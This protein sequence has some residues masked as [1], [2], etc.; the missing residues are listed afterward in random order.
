MQG[1]F[2]LRGEGGG[3]RPC[4][5]FDLLL[6][7]SFFLLKLSVFFMT[8]AVSNWDICC[9]KAL[10]LLCDHWHFLRCMAFLPPLPPHTIRVKGIV[11]L[12][13]NF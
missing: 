3:D 11:S 9:I 10:L 13:K 2:L 6:A 1:V 7:K 5:C 8:K 4:L 12:R